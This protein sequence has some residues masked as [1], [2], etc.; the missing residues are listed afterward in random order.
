MKKAFFFV[1]IAIVATGCS[2]TATSARRVEP[3][4]PSAGAI[5][6]LTDAVRLRTVSE[7][8]GVLSAAAEF[9]GFRELVTKHFPLTHAKLDLEIVGEHSLLYSWGPPTGEAIL[10]AAHYDVVPTESEE[11]SVGPFAG[12]VDEN[13]IW[14]RGT[15]DNK[16]SVMAILEAVE[17]LIAE[18]YEPQGRIYLAFGHDEENEGLGAKLMASA[19]EKRGER[20]AMVLDEG[21]FVVEGIVDG[22]DRPLASVGVAEKGYV[23]VELVTAGIGGH[24]SIPPKTTAV[25][26]IARAIALLED[27][28][29]PA[30]VIPVT[31][32][33]IERV[34]TVMSWG[35]R[36]ALST[37]LISG[38]LIKMTLS[39]SPETEAMLRTTTAATLVSGGVKSNVLPREARAVVNFRILPGDTVAEVLEHVRTTIDDDAVT[40]GPIGEPSEA[41]PVSRTEGAAYEAIAESIRECFPEA[42][43]VPSLVVGM[44]DSRRY[45][46]IARDVYRF[47]P[48]RMAKA[49]LSRMHGTNERISRSGYAGMIGFYRVLIPRLAGRKAL[50]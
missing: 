38:P 49:D 34:A 47:L 2:Q 21:G 43:L 16:S 46:S 40:V 37:P 44:T 23:N 45:Q 25:G 5:E 27:H 12:T 42:L 15:L 11:W 9:R 4:E 8:G 1:V 14:G 7:Q 35:R 24:S 22:V 19:L 36:A 30:R 13:F 6:R 39:G 41:S 32:T 31:R 33:Q 26:R 10:L 3:G 17:S 18:G 29:M 48:I 28:P 50:H 20:L